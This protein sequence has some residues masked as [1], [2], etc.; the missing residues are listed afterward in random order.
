MKFLDVFNDA[1]DTHKALEPRATSG[2]TVLA[3]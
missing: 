2:S 1:A 3:I